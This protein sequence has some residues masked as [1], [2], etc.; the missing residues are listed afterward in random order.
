MT[1][2]D[3]YINHD[4]VILDHNKNKKYTFNIMKMR[5]YIGFINDDDYD[6]YCKL[7]EKE[8]ELR[9][10]INTYEIILYENGKWINRLECQE[11]FGDIEEEKLT[12]YKKVYAYKK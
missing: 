8:M 12:I 2:C 3:Y 5:G 4:I 10:K 7:F 6:E 1:D 11:L 9:L